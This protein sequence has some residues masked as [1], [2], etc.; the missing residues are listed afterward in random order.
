[1]LDIV[2][3]LECSCNYYFIQVSDWLAGGNAENAGN[4]LA[5]AAMEF[6]LGITT[7]LEL[8]ERAGRLPTKDAKAIIKPNEGWYTADV[9]M[10]GFG[11]G[12]SRFTPV[13]LANYAATIGNGGTLYSLSFLRRIVSSD[14]TETLFEQTPRILNQIE[15]TEYIEI[16][17][18]GMLAVS[19]GSR[20]TA[21]DIFRNYR[22]PVA[23]KTGTVQIEGRRINDGV[24]VCYAPADNPEI[25]IS[26][27]IE[28]GGSGSQ[29]MA[30]A[31]TIMD[32]YF[33]TESTFMATPYGQMVP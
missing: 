31:R 2:Q 33:V 23:A 6:G 7:G 3:A 4:M 18:E 30:I 28:K 24:F 13:Q 32:H 19:M 25:A 15:E 26:I 8:P 16:L 9:L 21:R 5:E 20:G 10:A 12:E 11:Q 27:V 1:V 14:F 22:I 29:V 17:Q